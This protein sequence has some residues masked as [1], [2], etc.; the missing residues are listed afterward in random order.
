MKLD[1]EER[2]KRVR[3]AS[4]DADKEQQ[5]R[6][7]IFHDRE[8]ERQ[9]EDNERILNQE[10]VRKTVEFA[11]Q[12]IIK[13]KEV[14]DQIS[15]EE[16][17]KNQV[18]AGNALDKEKERQVS[19][20]KSGH[21][22][23]AINRGKVQKNVRLAVD[24][25]QK[26]RIKDEE[27]ARKLENEERLKRVR[28]ASLDVDKEKERRME[29]SKT[30][31]RE[32]IQSRQENIKIVTLLA[33]TERKRRIQDKESRMTPETSSLLDAYLGNEDL[34]LGDKKKDTRSTILR[35]KAALTFWND[36]FSEP[37]VLNNSF[38]VAI[39][40][41]LQKKKL[42][43]D[44]K[45][46]EFFLNELIAKFFVV[47]PKNT[48]NKDPQNYVDMHSVQ[49][50]I[51]I[52][53]PW[54]QL[55]EM[56]SN[57]FFTSNYTPRPLD[58]FY[59]RISDEK[60]KELLIKGNEAKSAKKMRFLIRYNVNKEGNC[61]LVIS[62]IRRGKKKNVVYE[63]MEVIRSKI[64][65]RKKKNKDST[66][67]V[68]WRYNEAIPSIGKMETRIHLFA[69]LANTL[70]YFKGSHCEDIDH[71]HT[72]PKRIL[73]PV[74]GPGYVYE[75]L[76]ANEESSEGPDTEPE[77]IKFH[78][79]DEEEA[80]SDATAQKIEEEMRGEEDSSQKKTTT[81]SSTT[82]T[83]TTSHT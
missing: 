32:E 76:N 71:F 56:I 78:N 31:E 75:K 68:K 70:E 83:T 21:E 2:I 49:F 42:I 38:K 37:C 43:K 5:R 59:G 52:F 29:I 28:K 41:F 74:W 44:E 18:K 63:D 64:K 23:D 54:I 30:L 15:K 55:F 17:I 36:H 9:I 45:E 26:R 82:T 50:A 16:R 58:V 7:L 53:G 27:N 34:E 3:K 8:R 14:Q 24:F 13:E 6:M 66:G 57:H 39:K 77:R 22:T 73:T 25:E 4:Q 20:I 51:N 1:K 12:R 10:E 60:T 46:L 47:D 19:E 61:V 79:Y 69:N 48:K 65:S 33:E 67:G 35:D 62:S 72:I 80:T 81:T 40:K 11:Q